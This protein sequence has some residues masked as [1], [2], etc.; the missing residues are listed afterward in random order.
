M[1]SI[2]GVTILYGLIGNAQSSRM[3]IEQHM[4]FIYHRRIFLCLKNKLQ[5]V[6][7]TLII[8]HHYGVWNDRVQCGAEYRKRNREDFFVMALHEMPIDR[9]PHRIFAGIF[10]GRKI[11]QN[12]YLFRYDAG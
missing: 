7:F 8:G 9:L 2:A 1:L 12:A 10:R 5:D 4:E 11:S 6:V 3:I